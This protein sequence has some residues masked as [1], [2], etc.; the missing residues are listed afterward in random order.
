MFRSYFRRCL[1][2]ARAIRPL[3]IRRS[4]PTS[5]YIN[6]RRN[7]RIVKPSHIIAIYD[8]EPPILPCGDRE[9]RDGAW[10]IGQN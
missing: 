6:V 1:L 8:E 3:V 4:A 9:V 7:V 2:R 5:P 10:L